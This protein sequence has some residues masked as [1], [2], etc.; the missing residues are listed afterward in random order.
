MYVVKYSSRETLVGPMAGEER[1]QETR[2]RNA[3]CSLS[4]F[5]NKNLL[6][7]NKKFGIGKVGGKREIQREK[8]KGRRGEEGKGGE[9]RGE[10][11]VE[12]EKTGKA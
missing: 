12:E 3:E 2:V 5:K 9:S 10:E 11:W 1:R 4:L 7:I 6:L 8:E